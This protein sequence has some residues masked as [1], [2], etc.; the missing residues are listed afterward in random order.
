MSLSDFL[1]FFFRTHENVF[2]W[3]TLTA[4]GT[5]LPGLCDLVITAPRACPR[6]EL[7]C[8]LG[9]AVRR[10]GSHLGY[11]DQKERESNQY[12]MWLS[13]TIICVRYTFPNYKLMAK[14]YSCSIFWTIPWD[15]IF[16][17]I[18]SRYRRIVTLS[19]IPLAA[20]SQAVH[21]LALSRGDT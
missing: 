9:T 18:E 15:T 2:F 8:K 5:S 12:R 20:E 6:A 11:L 14:T 19:S 1:W 16:I 10:A 13:K 3:V 4:A 7:K 17:A 21:R